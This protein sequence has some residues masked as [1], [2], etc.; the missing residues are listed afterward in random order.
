MSSDSEQ[1]VPKQL[2]KGD[3]VKIRTRKMT[4]QMLE[5]LKLAREKAHNVVRQ[6]GIIARQ[7]K[8]ERSKVAMELAREYVKKGYAKKPVEEEV[9]KEDDEEEVQE[10]PKLKQKKSPPIPIEKPKDGVKKV[11]KQ[12]TI[13]YQDDKEDEKPDEEIVKIVKPKKP[14]VKKAPTQLEIPQQHTKPLSMVDD[15]INCYY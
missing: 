12:K 2:S 9:Q 4:P 5:K 10:K 3:V 1:E 7:I 13:Y 15:I 11:I 14:R 8:S 6:K